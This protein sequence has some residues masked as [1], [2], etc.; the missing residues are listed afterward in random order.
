MNKLSG[1]LITSFI[2][3]FTLPLLSI[4]DLELFGETRL[5]DDPLRYQSRNVIKRL[6]A[7]I[8]CYR[9][10]IPLIRSCEC[11]KQQLLQDSTATRS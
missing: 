3:V 2:S 10:E 4:L 9:N 8:N 7:R 5:A 11:D 6:C 1:Y